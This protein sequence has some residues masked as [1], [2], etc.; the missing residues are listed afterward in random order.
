LQRYRLLVRG[1]EAGR[2]CARAEARRKPLANPVGVEGLGDV[3]SALPSPIES[4][5]SRH[6]ALCGFSV[7]GADEVPDNCPRL[8]EDAAELFVGDIGVSPPLPD[9]QFGEI[10]DDIVAA[11][12]EVIAEGPQ[13]GDELRGRT[14]ARAVH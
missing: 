6:P 8:G 10:F 9:E 14:F 2:P 3:K 13:A 4:L 1:R 11:V 12:A 7:R 5:F